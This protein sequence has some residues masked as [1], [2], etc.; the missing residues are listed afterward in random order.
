MCIRDSRKTVSIVGSGPSGF[1]TA[2]H[3]LKKSPIPLNV[4][5]WEKLPVPFGLSRYGVAPDHP[6]VKNCE[7]TFTTCAEEFSSPT[8]QKHKFS[9]VGGITI[10]KEILLKELLDNQDAVILSYGCT[11]VS[12]TH[13]D[14]YKRQKV[15]PS[16]IGAL[17]LYDGLI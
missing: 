8:N 4:T 16:I 13:L 6:E 7:E 2:Y 17:N 14:V 5:I 1:Y 9:F 11:A 10:G 12:Y 15:D 3:L